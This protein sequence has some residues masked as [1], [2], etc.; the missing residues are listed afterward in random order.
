MGQYKAK[1]SEI[2]LKGGMQGPLNWYNVQVHGFGPEDD[3]STSSP[4]F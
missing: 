2:M 3:K 1:Y 4:K